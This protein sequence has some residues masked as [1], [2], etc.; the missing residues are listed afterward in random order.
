M[1]RIV[2]VL[3]VVVIATMVWMSSAAPMAQG[4]QGA[5]GAQSGQGAPPAQGRGG[6]AQADPWPGK[7]HLLAVA[8]VQSGFHH[9]SISHAL[10]TVE[11]IGRKADAYMGKDGKQYVVIAASGGTNV[12][13]GLPI[14]DS[15]VAYRL[16]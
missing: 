11:Q 5:Q 1:R 10:A 6:G 13:A 14:S 15:L 9:D 3:P 7:K 8:D 16:P 12:G 2:I 4:R